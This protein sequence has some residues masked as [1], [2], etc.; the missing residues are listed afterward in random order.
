M[1]LEEAEVFF[2]CSKNHTNL[3]L[4]SQKW[5]K[6]VSWQVMFGHIG[7]RGIRVGSGEYW[8]DP[9]NTGNTMEAFCDMTTD[10]GKLI[11]KKKTM[12]TFEHV[13]LT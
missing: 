9:A 8:I 5:N 13:V 7:Q 4:N 6:R 11:M 1:L 10:G 12:A 2:Y 3:Y